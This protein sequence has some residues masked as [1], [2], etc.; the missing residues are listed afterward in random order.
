MTTEVRVLGAT[1]RDGARGL[2]V[3]ATTLLAPAI[4]LL[5]YLLGSL[6]LTGGQVVDGRP[7]PW[8]P[9]VDWPVFTL[10]P[11]L[12]VPLA[13]GAL[14]AVV[15]HA[16]RVTV[17]RALVVTTLLGWAAASAGSLWFFGL[18]LPPAA[19]FSEPLVGRSDHLLAAVIVTLAA[20]VLIV[21][22][23]MIGRAHDRLVRA[24]LIGTG[25]LMTPEG[26][27][28]R[29]P[30]VL[31][32]PVGWRLDGGALLPPDSPTAGEAALSLHAVRSAAALAPTAESTTFLTA[33]GAEVRRSPARAGD[34]VI[35]VTYV[36]APAPGRGDATQLDAIVRP[37]AVR[38]GGEVD[39]LL[40]TADTIASTFRWR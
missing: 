32:A 24:R 1:E 34:D 17:A 40:A 19:L 30:F 29:A 15:V 13:L 21:R 18:V 6:V 16:R 31:D 36:F 38:S 23:A 8:R 28:P 39:A 37:S 5:A 14:A 25:V 11:W 9:V 12:T 3:A 27:D 35:T 22:L 33:A 7:A 4:L 20:A 2:I 26:W 10:S